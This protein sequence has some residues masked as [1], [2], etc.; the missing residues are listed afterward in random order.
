MFKFF[1]LKDYAFLQQSKASNVCFFSLFNVMNTEN[2]FIGFLFDI[3]H[4]RN[5]SLT[6]KTSK[7]TNKPLSPRNWSQSNLARWFRIVPSVESKALDFSWVEFSSIQFKSLFSLELLEA[8][9]LTSK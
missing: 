3:K 9:G 6:F 5:T 4:L 7:Q 1:Q 2:Y 8:Q